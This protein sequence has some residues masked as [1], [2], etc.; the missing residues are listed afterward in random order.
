MPPTLGSFEIKVYGAP[1]AVVDGLVKV[2]NGG[3]QPK[4]YKQ[5]APKNICGEYLF[6]DPI[7][8]AKRIEESIVDI[9]AERV[10]SARVYHA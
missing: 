6:E 3:L 2:P 8:M 4:L 5:L 1:Y 9:Q 10:R 7:N